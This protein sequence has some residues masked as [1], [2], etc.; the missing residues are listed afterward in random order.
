MVTCSGEQE[1]TPMHVYGASVKFE[2]QT[3]AAQGASSQEAAELDC[4]YEKRFRPPLL[5]L[6]WKF[7]WETSD[8]HHFQAPN[9]PTP[10][11]P[12][13]FP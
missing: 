8:S 6:D 10:K 7:L 5:F 11:N 3:A 1:D 9:H 13:F 2:A 12:P 4:F